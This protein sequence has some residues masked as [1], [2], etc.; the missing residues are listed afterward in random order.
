[1]EALRLP[2]VTPALIKNVQPEYTPEALKAGIEGT[3]MV[4]GE[5]GVDGRAYRPRVVRGL[6]YGLDA[7]AL[8]ALAQW[9]FIPA[10]RNGV[11]VACPA[12][13]EINFRLPR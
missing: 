8:D 4:G 1:V 12:T 13:T 5:I 11:P 2:Q 3:V 10:K 9:R 6:G 7:K